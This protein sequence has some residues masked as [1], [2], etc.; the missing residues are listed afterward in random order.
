METLHFDIHMETDRHGH[1][2]IERITEIEPEREG[3]QLR[4]ILTFERGT[5]RQ[6]GRIGKEHGQRIRRFY[7]GW[8]QEEAADVLAG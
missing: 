5:Y 3:Y 1:R 6:A 8:K 7:E 4:E 2:Y